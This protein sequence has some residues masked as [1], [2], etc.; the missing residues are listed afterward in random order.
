MTRRIIEIVVGLIL[1]FCLIANYTDKD[2]ESKLL[3]WYL[4]TQNV[5]KVI[6]WLTLFFITGRLIFGEYKDYSKN[7]YSLLTKIFGDP[8]NE[9][10]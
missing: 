4:L 10:K 3:I 8:K 7:I 9:K 2:H 1:A 5:L 6:V